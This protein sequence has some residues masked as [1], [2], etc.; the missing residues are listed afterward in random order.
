MQIRITLIAF[1]FTITSSAQFVKKHGQLKVQGTQL[2][3]QN[4]ETI[5]LRGVS[6]G[7]H[8]WWPQFYNKQTVKWLHNDWNVNVLRAAMGVDADDNCYL[9]SPKASQ[10]KL[11]AV[12]NAAIKED[13]YVII[14]WHSHNIH[15]EEAKLFFDEMS[16]KY[17]KYPN[18]IYEIFNEPERQSWEEVKAYSEQVIAVIRKNDPDNIIL[19]GS[20]SWDQD[21]HL[22]AKDPIKGYENL[23]YTMH[24]YAATH[25]KWLRDRVDQAMAD[26]LPI[27]ISESAGTE[28]T[29]DGKLDFNAWQEYIDWMES[30][31]LSWITWSVSSKDESCS[32]LLP[33]ASSKG[34]WKEKDLRASG[35][36]TREYL[37]KLNKK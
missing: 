31:K 30:K 9:K 17:G 18:V 23:M 21:V 28:A 19:V 37:R 3:N 22:P 13:I 35:K 33:S 16:K 32:F 24:F 12:V 1:F 8:N 5:S 34:N 29:G 7:W 26:G 6:L 20:P 10:A 27:F 2:V 14:D 25:E 11:E 36:K 4:G 15:L